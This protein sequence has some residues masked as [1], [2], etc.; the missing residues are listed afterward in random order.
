MKQTTASVH[1]SFVYTACSEASGLGRQFSSSPVWKSREN[2]R[3]AWAH[4][5]IPFLALTI[6]YIHLQSEQSCWVSK[7]HS[8]SEDYQMTCQEVTEPFE[9]EHGRV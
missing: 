7:M 5:I 2:S 8:G 6:H 9:N 3:E 1:S 4:P